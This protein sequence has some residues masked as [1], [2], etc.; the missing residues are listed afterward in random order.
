MKYT[1]LDI[2]VDETAEV[3]K[4]CPSFQGYEAS[5]FGR[6]RSVV[7]RPIPK[8]LPGARTP[9]VNPEPFRKILSQRLNPSGYAIVTLYP[10]KRPTLRMTHAL[11][12]DAFVGPRPHGAMIQHI[13]GDKVNNALSNLRYVYNSSVTGGPGGSATAAL[14]GEYLPQEAVWVLSEKGVVRFF[15]ETLDQL[16]DQ[17]NGESD[18]E[19]TIEFNFD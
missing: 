2:I 6:V 9:V 18:P 15:A 5:N 10:S 7:P 16:L 12:M 1:K 8:V 11:V 19:D 3:W 14:N 4:P 17:I 13:D